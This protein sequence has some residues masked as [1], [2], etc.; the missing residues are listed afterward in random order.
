ML[1]KG[2][3]DMKTKELL[4]ETLDEV[5]EECLNEREQK[6]IRLRYG[7]DDNICHTLEEIGHELVITRERVRQIESKAIK[8]LSNFIAL[9]R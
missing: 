7:L 9:Q 1:H 6:V 4:R 3:Q 8:K 5:I 2:E